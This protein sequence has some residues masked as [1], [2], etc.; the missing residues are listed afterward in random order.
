MLM[1]LIPIAL[2]LLP[3]LAR[4]LVGPKAGEIA[5]TV[6]S[7]VASVI[8]TD[9]PIAVAAALNDPAKAADLRIRLAEI[10][11]Q[12]DAAQHAARLEEMKVVVGDIQNARSTMVK[13]AEAGSSISWGAPVVSIVIVVGFF[14]SFAILAFG[15]PVTDANSA[16]ML[17][18]LTGAIGAGFTAV[19]GYWLGSSAGSARKDALLTHMSQQTPPQLTTDDL[20]A[21]EL[22]R[23]KNK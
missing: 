14:I 16:A 6:S 8:G 7:T 1:P 20:N 4:W 13:L 18:I 19:V 23:V 12:A 17:N 3:D 11:S 5:S 15:S 22:N 9:D 21:R 10:A 2:T